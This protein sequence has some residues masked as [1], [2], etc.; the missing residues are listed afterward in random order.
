MKT[1][2][3]HLFA[4]IVLIAGCWMSASLLW[5][6][7]GPDW[8]I[9]LAIAAWLFVSALAWGARRMSAKVWICAGLLILAGLF[10]PAPMLVEIFPD[11]LSLPFE[12]LRAIT[13]F[14]IPSVALVI[15]ALLLHSGLNLH[16]EW[17]N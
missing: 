11:R 9:V 8:L 17:Q 15:A 14:L 2:V 7:L 3:F 12:T 5:G 1:K 13:L 16:Q 6:S 4:L 10:L